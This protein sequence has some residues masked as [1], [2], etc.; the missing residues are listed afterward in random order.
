M[1]KFIPLFLFSNYILETPGVTQASQ[2]YCWF[3][4]NKMCF[5]L[6]SV[7]KANLLGTLPICSFGRWPQNKLGIDLIPHPSHISTSKCVTDCKL[8]LCKHP[9]TMWA[10]SC[11]S[12]STV[13]TDTSSAHT[14]WGHQ[15]THAW[16]GPFLTLCS[17]HLG[18]PSVAHHIRIL[19][20]CRRV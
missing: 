8:D 1:A 16:L 17:H 12:H 13:E 15:R 20:Y 6:C 3:N 18:I 7:L 19:P 11:P 5:Q 9:F 4:K 14:C 10:F 2:G